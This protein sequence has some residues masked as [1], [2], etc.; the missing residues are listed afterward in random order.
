MAKKIIDQKGKKS[1][2]WSATD[3]QYISDQAGKIS[4]ELI[5]SK[6]GKNAKKVREYMTKQGLMKYYYKDELEKDQL[7][8]IRKSK[9]WDNLVEQF[10]AKELDFFEY[11]WQNM[12][13]QFR[14]DILHTEE[15]QIVDTIKLQL[16]M[17]RN[18]KK[19]K[20]AL[21]HIDFLSKEIKKEQAKSP[22]DQKIIQSY[23]Q[24]LAACYSGIEALDKDHIM[25]LKEK[26]NCLHKLKAT[27]EGRITQY[28]NSKE[29]LVGWIKKLYTDPKLRYELG[30]KMEKMRI[31]TQVEYERLSMPHKF[32]D[33]MIDRPILNHKTVCMTSTQ[34]NIENGENIV[35]SET[36]E[37]MNQLEE[38]V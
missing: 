37:T 18:Q 12:V 29:T 30:L 20:Q 7:L 23:S 17:D 32:A 3:K 26:N 9:Y 24:D 25:L 38:N 36:T 10:D 21:D 22:S 19:Q 6:L 16:M 35:T 28:E 2:P 14:D 34:N 1:G 33:G 8:N 15:L 5:A 4:P 13:R 27:R 31:A 11:H